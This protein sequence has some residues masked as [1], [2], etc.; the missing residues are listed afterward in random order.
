MVYGNTRVFRAEKGVGAA[1]I[2][3]SRLHG[4][5]NQ[6]SEPHVS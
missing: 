4:R 6:V 5:V 3:C 1:A 2:R